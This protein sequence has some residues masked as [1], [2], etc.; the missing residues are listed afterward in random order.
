MFSGN[1]N[2]HR[3]V[4]AIFAFAEEGIMI[5]LCVGDCSSFFL[6]LDVGAHGDHSQISVM[7]AAPQGLKVW[8]KRVSGS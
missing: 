5:P 1:I 6:G 8:S 3:S 4:C 7:A 2:G